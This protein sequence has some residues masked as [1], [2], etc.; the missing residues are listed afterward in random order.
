MWL[1]LAY[2][3]GHKFIL[4]A[5]EQLRMPGNVFWHCLEA[6]R[7]TV[8]VYLSLFSFWHELIF[9]IDSSII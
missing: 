5:N 9:D 4:Y 6:I 3:T 7:C 2:A 1:P 8:A